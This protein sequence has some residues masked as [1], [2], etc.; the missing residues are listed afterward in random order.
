MLGGSN[1]PSGWSRNEQSNTISSTQNENVMAKVNNMK[2]LYEI[3]VKNV[4]ASPVLLFSNCVVLAHSVGVAVA[5][6]SGFGSSGYVLG[7]PKK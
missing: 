5:A 3:N 1:V 4:T 2:M 7:K 6:V